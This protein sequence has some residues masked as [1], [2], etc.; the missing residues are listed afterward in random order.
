[1]YSHPI[2]AGREH[3]LAS[4]VSAHRPT[5]SP[6]GSH[7]YGVYQS[8]PKNIGQLRFCSPPD[9]YGCGPASTQAVSRMFPTS[10]HEANPSSR[11]RYLVERSGA[12]V[13]R[14][15][16]Q[17]QTKRAL[18]TS[19]HLSIQAVYL[20]RRPPLRLPRRLS[21]CDI[22]PPIDSNIAPADGESTLKKSTRR[23]D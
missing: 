23:A 22:V 12:L 17:R 6:D 18:T 15:R 3:S 10:W 1:M 21:S 7:D 14:P 9:R 19:R 8:F 4:T 11:R 20:G 16:L 13:C 2:S 5:K